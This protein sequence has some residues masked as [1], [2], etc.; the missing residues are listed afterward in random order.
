MQRQCLWWCEQGFC[1]LHTK[2][3]TC[4]WSAQSCKHSYYRNLRV[5][6]IINQSLKHPNYIF[7]IA[8][9]LYASLFL[10]LL[11]LINFFFFFL[12]SF[13]LQ[14][15]ST[16][17]THLVADHDHTFLSVYNGFSYPLPSMQNCIWCIYLSMCFM[18]M[19]VGGCVYVC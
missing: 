7:R 17:L 2:K 15:I 9:F 14:N 3:N 8:A 11:P 12:Q 4:L 18:S 19:S 10:F 5:R 6:T 16:W 1:L 13:P